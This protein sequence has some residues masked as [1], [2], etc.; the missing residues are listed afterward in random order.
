MTLME[1]PVLQQGILNRQGVKRLVS[2]IAKAFPK[3]AMSK[4]DGSIMLDI[5]GTLT[6]TTIL[7]RAE[8]D[9]HNE[10]LCCLHEFTFI[11]DREPTFYICDDCKERQELA[12]DWVTTK[13]RWNRQYDLFSDAL[14]ELEKAAAEIPMPPKTEYEEFIA[15]FEE[16]TALSQKQNQPKP[17]HLGGALESIE[18]IQ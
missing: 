4:S 9:F 2:K 13:T 16:V 17:F 5:P 10:R 3:L 14:D 7:K 12:W 8:A 11:G 6:P 15:E 1:I 18:R